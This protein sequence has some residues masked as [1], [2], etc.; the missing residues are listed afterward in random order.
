MEQSAKAFF[1]KLPNI[2]RQITTLLEELEKQQAIAE[3]VTA[4]LSSEGHG[5]GGVSRSLE[6]SVEK[7][8][9][10]RAELAAKVAELT[11]MTNTAYKILNLIPD[12]K[13]RDC[14]KNRYILGKTWE[15]VADAFG[16]TYQ[17]VCILHGRAL[18]TADEQIKIMF[19]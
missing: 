11:E 6:S 9:K 12:E 18:Q 15:Q 4:S 10:I 5:S 14:L 16:M 17:G 2:D 13:E 8:V 3:K 7:I 1:Q 19:G